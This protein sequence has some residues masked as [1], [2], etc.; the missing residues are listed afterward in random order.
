MATHCLNI[1]TAVPMITII[2][3]AEC[4]LQLFAGIITTVTF[5]LMMQISKNVP[6]SIQAT[7]FSTLATFEVLG[8]LFMTSVGGSLVEVLGYLHFFI[9]CLALSIAVL[10]ALSYYQH[11]HS[12]MD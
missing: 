1:F 10:P 8:K 9:F 6:T 5:T 2:L 12:H 4:I 3:V 11:T 7:H